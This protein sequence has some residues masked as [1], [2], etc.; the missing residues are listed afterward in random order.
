MEFGSEYVY[1]EG[2]DDQLATEGEEVYADE[3]AMGLQ[4]TYNATLTKKIKYSER[5]G[6][7]QDYMLE[8]LDTAG[9]EQFSAMRDLY[10]KNGQ[11][12]LLIY[13]V[14]ARSTF[15]D[16]QDIR[17]MI[18]RV[19]D[20]DH[21][22]MVL[23]GNKIDLVDQRVVATEE[24]LELARKW[25]VPFIETSA[26]NK[27]NIDEA[28]VAALSTMESR[29]P[30]IKVVVL[31]SGGV[32]KSAY[33]VQYVQGIFVQKY[34][35]TIE[36][37]YRKVVSVP[38]PLG[39]PFKKN[40]SS[41]SS[42]FSKL[43]SAFSKASPK[44]TKQPGNKSEKV[45]CEKFNLNV[46]SADLTS[47]VNEVGLT[48][49]EPV[50]CKACRGALSSLSKITSEESKQIWKCEFCDVANEVNIEKDEIP[51][52]ETVEYLLEPPAEDTS[53]QGAS[54]LT[55]L[56]LD[57]SGSMSVTSELPQSQSE[58]KRLRMK[59]K[60][61]NE[62][63]N[64]RLPGEKIEAEYISRYDCL[65]AAIDWHFKRLVVATPNMPVAVIAFNSDVMILGHS[66]KEEII[67][68]GDNLNDLE[69][70]V[71]AGRSLDVKGFKPVSESVD[72]FTK[73]IK[74]IQESGTTALGPAVTF[75]VALAGQRPKS[76][77][78]ICTDG[79]ANV[80]VGAFVSAKT[81][82]V[83][84]FYHSLGVIAKKNET[85]ISVIGIEGDKGGCALQTIGKLAD[86]TAGTT[87]ILLPIELITQ[88]V[89]ISPEANH[90]N[91]RLRSIPR[92]IQ[93][94]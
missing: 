37:S 29:T 34:D 90:C 36:D 61:T 39:E 56:L 72:F 52:N 21:I 64:Q 43:T 23:I 7:M 85:K 40:N 70:L 5:D 62:H 93:R 6:P 26:K 17:E 48:T 38:L 59:Q 45:Q 67:V 88:I 18:L 2:S 46:V 25:N 94:S 30:E 1:A 60:T 65:K 66:S 80:G 15:N 8:I 47:L 51:S 71:N 75:A 76:E 9:T 54:G 77:I 82:E 91:Q 44:Q 24:G 89:K 69:Y 73:K 53:D 22:A 63:A 57:I 50:F 87:N 58:W 74:S 81:G 28:M 86:L 84:E 16:L 49:G 19:K 92:T 42:W 68:T 3:L 20:V 31:G 35:P 11:V 14:I 12:F 78:I 79:L 10:M 33:V 32:G 13:S 41:S 27:V 4:S 83:E 55:I